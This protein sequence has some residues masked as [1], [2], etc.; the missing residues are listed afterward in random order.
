MCANFPDLTLE[1]YYDN[2]MKHKQEWIKRNLHKYPGKS[3]DQQRQTQYLKSAWEQKQITY[4]WGTIS[5]TIHSKNIRG[6]RRWNDSFKLM[7]QFPLPAKMEFQ[8]PDLVSLWR[9]PKTQQNKQKK[10]TKDK[11]MKQLFFKT[12]NLRQHQTAVL[13][14]KKTNWDPQQWFPDHCHRSVSTSSTWTGGRA[15]ATQG[16]RG[17]APWVEEPELRVQWVQGCYSSQG[18]VPESRE[19]HRSRTL[20]MWGVFS[21]VV[22][23][24]VRKLHESEEETTG[25]D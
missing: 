18:G 5:L 9:Q 2:P 20:C 17:G 12:L 6:N 1:F 14:E 7:R 21:Q 23:L 24:H 4:K 11:I 25:E 19:Q 22:V 8:K 15:R 16:G 10:H 13:E 3:T